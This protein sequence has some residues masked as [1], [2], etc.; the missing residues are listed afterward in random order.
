MN[1]SFK[2]VAKF[3]IVFGLCTFFQAYIKSKIAQVG[4]HKDLITI[5]KKVG[6]YDSGIL[7]LY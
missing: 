6:N 3:K 4:V 5:P 2:T 1:S 7:L